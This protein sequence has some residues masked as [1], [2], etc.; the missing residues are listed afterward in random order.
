MANIVLAG[1]VT[2]DLDILVSDSNTES[3]KYKNAIKINIDYANKGIENKLFTR[4]DI[5][6]RQ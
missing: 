3:S 6:K 1:S 5:Q 4:E 2:N